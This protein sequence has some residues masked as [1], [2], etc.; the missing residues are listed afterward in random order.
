MFLSPQEKSKNGHQEILC[1]P[2]PFPNATWGG[3][4]GASAATCDHED[5]RAERWK[6]L[7]LIA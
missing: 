1:F 3:P 6:E 7:T 2:W 5:G 4:P